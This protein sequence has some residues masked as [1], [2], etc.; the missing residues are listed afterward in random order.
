MSEQ[1]FKNVFSVKKYGFRK[2][3]SFHRFCILFERGE[4]ALQHRIGKFAGALQVSL[5]AVCGS[6]S[7]RCFT[8]AD[9]LRVSFVFGAGVLQVRL[10]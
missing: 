4:E 5:R 8:V 10:G 1:F 2:K 3:T 7:Y 6:F 9:G